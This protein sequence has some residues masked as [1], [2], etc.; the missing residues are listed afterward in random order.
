MPNLLDPLVEVFFD[1]LP[2]GKPVRHQHHESFSTRIVGQLSLGND[3]SVPF[4]EI[5][6]LL[7]SD[8]EILA[9][10]WSIR[11]SC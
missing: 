1:A 4:R 6:G 9:T 7:Y 3:L 2:D 11:L 10:H 8:T 5:S